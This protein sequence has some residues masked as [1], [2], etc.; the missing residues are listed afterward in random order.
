MGGPIDLALLVTYGP[1]G[2]MVVLLVTGRL[3]PGFV[4]EHY[5]RDLDAAQAELRDA[6]AKL[7]AND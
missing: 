7:E 4:V 5:Q 1:L 6:R 2:V 3:V